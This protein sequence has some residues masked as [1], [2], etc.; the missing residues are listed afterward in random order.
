MITVVFNGVVLTVKLSTG[1]P[2]LDSSWVVSNSG[3][4]TPI[5]LSFMRAY[6][7]RWCTYDRVASAL[8]DRLSDMGQCQIKGLITASKPMKR[9]SG[10]KY[11][12]YKM[13]CYLPKIPREI[14]QII[15]EIM[16]SVPETGEP[17]CTTE[18]QAPF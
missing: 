2:W 13:S 8:L 9:G 18:R 10:K 5:T 7:Q 4:E 11:P 1:G 14:E 16:E 17:T 6:Y 15:Q 12:G 3:P